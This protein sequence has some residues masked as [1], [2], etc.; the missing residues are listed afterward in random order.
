MIR[1][2]FNALV[3]APGCSC[4]ANRHR[5]S[6]G[7]L[8]DPDARLTITRCARC[9]HVWWIPAERRGLR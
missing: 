3:A 7:V 9:R 5:S 8:W 6:P 1:R 2:W 4:C